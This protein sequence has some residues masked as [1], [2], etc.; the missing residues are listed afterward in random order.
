MAL[1]GIMAGLAQYAMTAAFRIAPPSVLAPF[2]YTG[3]VW[4]VILGLI[5]WGEWPSRDVMIGASVIVTAGLYI[6]H[7]ER[8][9]SKRGEPSP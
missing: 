3:L 8:L 9:A 6:V 4:G 5:I 7:R 2:E 1:V